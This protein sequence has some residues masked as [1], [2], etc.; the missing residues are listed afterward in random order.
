MKQPPE[1]TLN[2]ITMRDLIAMFA[3]QGAL[4]APHRISP[5]AVA[6]NAYYLADLMLRARAVPHD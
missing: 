1:L 4:A 2:Q 3:M 6:S 5:D